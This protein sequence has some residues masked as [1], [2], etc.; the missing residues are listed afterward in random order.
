MEQVFETFAGGALVV[1]TIT[2][3]VGMTLYDVRR[4]QSDAQSRYSRRFKKRPLVSIRV[5]GEP[6]EQC[7]E[8]IWNS[9][10]QKIEV[11]ANKQ[12][13]HGKLVL[14]LQP[15]TILT[16]DAISRGVHAFEQDKS[17]D[18][19]EILPVIP[20]PRTIRQLIAHY[21]LIASGPFIASRAGLG[22]TPSRS[23]YPVMMR[24]K[25]HKSWRAPTYMTCC[26]FVKTALF[27]TLLYACNLTLM[28]NQSALFV[29]CLAG[30]AVWMIIAISYYPFMS[31]R[32]KM[33]YVLLVPVSI[34][35]FV[36]L[37][38]RT[39]IL[40]IFRHSYDNSAITILRASHRRRIFVI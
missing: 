16:T 39:V 3:L 27:I 12:L 5:Q 38:V 37:S 34:F 26:W 4:I 6:S 32:Q 22:I 8:S 14:W 2:T 11:I 24:P 36:L 25:V 31:Q 17:L 20:A 7:V 30:F 40:P 35:Y 15:N 33:V 29:A 13:T 9:D 10:Y 1:A 19:V 21:R 18:V 28:S 23:I